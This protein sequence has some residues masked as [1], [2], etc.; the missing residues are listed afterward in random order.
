MR[1]IT[2]VIE[3]DF[4][5]QGEWDA[6][7]LSRLHRMFPHLADRTSVKDVLCGLGLFVLRSGCFAKVFVI[8]AEPVN[9][10]MAI[11]AMNAMADTIAPGSY[12]K[13]IMDDGSCERI[14]FHP[15]GVALDPFHPRMRFSPTIVPGG[16]IHL[17]HLWV[18]HIN[19]LWADAIGGELHLTLDAS[20]VTPIDEEERERIEEG[21]I[22]DLCWAGVE[23][24]EV[25]RSYAIDREEIESVL[26]PSPF[27]DAFRS[28]KS[29]YAEE[30]YEKSM[31]DFIGG[32]DL[33]VRGE[34]LLM[35]DKLYE[36]FWAM[37]NLPTTERFYIPMVCD[38][39]GVKL[40]RSDAE[41]WRYSI[42]CFRAE[43]W[44]PTEVMGLLMDHCLFDRDEPIIRNG[45]LNLANFRPN[46]R[47]DLGDVPCEGGEET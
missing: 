34:D 37:A 35:T 44:T 30:V 21:T 38:P 32:Y 14:T 16:F 33:L 41:T 5:I 12:L 9:V 6:P 46:P 7:L 13:A 36:F 4:R 43:G 19:R 25:H 26:D 3:S 39:K 17:G 15:G 27:V 23:F 40:N 11:P 2:T 22:S 10:G 20:K 47:I 8:A 24:D 18:S 42:Q 1:D 29:P 31:M 28:G 45:R